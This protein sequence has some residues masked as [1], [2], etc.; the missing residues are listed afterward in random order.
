MAELIKAGEFVGR[1]EEPTARQ[2]ESSLPSSWTVICNKELVDPRGVSREVDFIVIG[3]HCVFVIDEKS[4]SGTLY[5]NENGWVL[6]SG[7]SYNNPLGKVGFIARRLAGMLRDNVPL[8]K[9]SVTEHFVFPRMVMSSST[10]VVRVQDPRV[11]VEVL[12]LGT[13]SEKLREFDESR[14]D[15]GASIGR[16]RR[17][18]VESLVALHNRPKIP[19]YIGD[20]EILESLD[21]TDTSRLLRAVHEDGS[22]RFLR[23]IRQPTTVDPNKQKSQKNA[24]LREYESLKR[25]AAQGVSPSVDPYFSWEDRS[26]WVIPMHPIVGRTLRA[27][28]SS[29]PPGRESVP[30]T[31]E[32]AFRALARIHNEGVVHRGLTPDRIFITNS[33]VKFAD[34]LIAR[35]V[36]EMTVVSQAAGIDP[37]NFYWAP[38]CRLGLELST[39][40]SDV[41]SLAVSLHFWITGIDA[42]EERQ[43]ARFG[44]A[45]PDLA[46]M[47]AVEA[48]FARCTREDDRV[49][50]SASDLA[51]AV[52]ALN[53]Q[54]RD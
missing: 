9:R 47:D 27:D 26:Y 14:K 24:L 10:A 17:R 15:D 23:L 18:I 21:S 16:F 32:S 31:I 7:E 2:L 49:R 48:I 30:R 1:G 43:F 39:A 19:R 36:G 33:G 11:K 53:R 8:L 38:E 5:G 22:E 12:Q 45:R 34:F 42:T 51:E 50:P 52:A 20:Y 37:E 6:P 3:D 25:L 35:I 46:D 28:R 29:A 4:W 13:V 54:N 44:D 41:Y 40:A